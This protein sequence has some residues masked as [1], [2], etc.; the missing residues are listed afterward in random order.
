MTPHFGISRT[1]FN[2]LDDLDLIK[3]Q[4]LLFLYL[5]H[6]RRQRPQLV[7]PYYTTLANRRHIYCISPYKLLYDK[8]I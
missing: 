5:S 1:N 8:K 3:L 7:V 6:Y 2:N 4:Q